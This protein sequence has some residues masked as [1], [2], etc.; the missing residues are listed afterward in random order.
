MLFLQGTRDALASLDLLQAVVH[1]LGSRATLH[2]AERADHSFH[3]PARSGRTDADVRAE[4]VSTLA[5]WT[6]SVTEAWRPS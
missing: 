1:R 5:A 6:A 2:L 3:V 4:L